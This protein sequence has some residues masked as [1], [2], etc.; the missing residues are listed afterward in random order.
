MME[1]PERFPSTFTP[2]GEGIYRVSGMR[3]SAVTNQYVQEDCWNC[4]HKRHNTDYCHERGCQCYWM[5]HKRPEKGTEYTP[6][7]EEVRKAYTAIFNAGHREEAG[8]E[9]DR[10]LERY[11][12]ILTDEVYMDTRRITLEEIR[13][14]PRET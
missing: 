6:S 11:S 13:R 10:W 7:T 9:F 14:T 8:R 12:L 3:R 1:T 2:V 5:K 4:G